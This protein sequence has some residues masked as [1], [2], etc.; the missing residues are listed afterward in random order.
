MRTRA[1]KDQ[2][3]ALLREKIGRANTLILA[4]YRGLT[5]AELN[6]LRQRLRRTGDQ[7]EYRV[8]K[9][10][11]LRRALRDTPGE[12]AAVLATGPTALA[13]AYDEPCALSKTLVD[14]AREN[15][16]FEIKGGLVEGEV[17]D[18][19]SI[20]TIAALP[21]MEE[22]RARLACGLASPLRNLAG[23][24]HALLGGVRSA[25]DQRLGQ[26]ES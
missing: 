5:V 25:L 14:Y 10:T 12:P 23:T 24:L 20:R 15:E 6:D 8:T 16:K 22:L 1:E 13:L 11:M 7:T 17:V 3:V 26:L 18:L 4:D 19:A 9:N 2:E 21:P